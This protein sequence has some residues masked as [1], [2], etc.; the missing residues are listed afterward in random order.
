MENELSKEKKLISRLFLGYMD[1]W[2]RNEISQIVNSPWNDN[3]DV[4]LSEIEDLEYVILPHL[5]EDIKMMELFD[6]E[7]IA[8]MVE[9]RH[10][11]HLKEVSRILKKE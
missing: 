1:L 11:Q 2:F 5:E 9:K 10:K 6:F 4:I 7:T 8:E 3:V